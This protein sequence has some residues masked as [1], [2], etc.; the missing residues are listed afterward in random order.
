MLSA[1]VFQLFTDT[2]HSKHI[3]NQKRKI[4]VLCQKKPRDR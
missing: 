3:T 1:I 2:L 4:Q